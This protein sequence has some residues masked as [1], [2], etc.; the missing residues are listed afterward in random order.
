MKPPTK[1]ELDRFTRTLGDELRTA[2]KGLGWTRKELR[3]RMGRSESD[4]LSLQ[5]LATYE[6]G[7]RRITVER[8]LEICVVLGQQPDELLLRATNRALVIEQPRHI[9]V[10]LA[11]VTRSTDPRL[12][13]IRKWAIVRA[14]QQQHHQ[15]LDLPVVEALDSGAL[16]ALA[17]ITGTD[18]YQL[19]CALRDLEGV[20]TT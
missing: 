7:T 1:G 3:S 12:Q 9:Q 14:Q 2:R 11:A 6:L 16:T 15:R 18:E 17:G 13:P 10:D 19:I 5:T 4:E 8:L 20:A